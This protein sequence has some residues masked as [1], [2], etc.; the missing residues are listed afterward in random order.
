MEELG[1]E[2]YNQPSESVL[3]ERIIHQA[4]QRFDTTL[5]INVTLWGERHDATLTGSVSNVK[6]GNLS[7]GDVSSAMLRGIVENLHAMMSQELLDCLK[8]IG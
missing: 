6:H 4:N 5:G 8:V 1:I 3:Y 2:K 7:L